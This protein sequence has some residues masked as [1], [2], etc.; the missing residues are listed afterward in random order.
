MSGYE[1]EFDKKSKADPNAKYKKAKPVDPYPSGGHWITKDGRHILIK[2]YPRLFTKVLNACAT[3]LNRLNSQSDNQIILKTI[4]TNETAHQMDISEKQLALIKTWEKENYFA[5]NESVQS[6]RN[7]AFESRNDRIDSLLLLARVTNTEDV[8]VRALKLALR[9]GEANLG[10][11]DEQANS[12]LSLSQRARLGKLPTKILFGMTQVDLFTPEVTD[13]LRSYLISQGLRT[14]P[15][16]S[17]VDF[18]VYAR[19]NATAETLLLDE[20]HKRDSFYGDTS[21]F[22]DA[23]PNLPVPYYR[24]L[25][26]ALAYGPDNVI[27]LIVDFGGSL[28]PGE[29][30]DILGLMSMVDVSNKVEKFSEIKK[31]LDSSPNIPEAFRPILLAEIR[32][33][34]GHG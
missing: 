14:I 26:A 5:A 13:K 33:R 6:E 16:H 19:G 29:F 10:F 15:I 34:L 31:A 23:K 18:R 17:N 3:A 32:K 30:R 12:I 28:T 4:G 9:L 21:S 8:T 2:D 24:D 20:S 27:N 11:T 7:R 1:E 25:G 22:R